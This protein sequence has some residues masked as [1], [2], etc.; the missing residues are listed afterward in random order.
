MRFR[1][2][3]SYSHADAAWAGWLLRRLET[4]RVPSRLVGTQGAHGLIERRLG[5]FFR[6]RDELP[7]AGDLGVTI[8]E[9]LADS[10]ALV[11]ICSPTAAQS[12]WVN[13]EVEAFQAG[14]HGDRVFCFVVGGVPGSVD[15]AQACFPPALVRP[16][17]NGEP[18]EP[19]AAD[20]RPEGDGRER[21]FLKLVA[22]LLGVGYDALAQREA[23]RR[24]RK[25]AIVAAAS[26]VGMTIAL[27][28]AAT[29]Y[30]ARNDA[31][32]RQAQAED[33]LGFMLGDLREK[34]TTVG[35]LDLMRSV[36]DKAIGY[37]ATLDPRDMT[38][39]ALEEQA[40]SLT[41]IGE[42]RLGEGNHDAAMAAFREAHAR[43][44]ALHQR[45]PD[46]GQRLFDLAQAEY[47]IGFVALEQGRY[48]DVEIWFRKY[49]DSAIKLAAMDRGNFEWQQEV[50]YG[51]HNL[52]ALDER[53]GRYV[54]AEKGMREV[55]RMQRE[56]SAT[57]PDDTAMRGEMAETMSWLGQVSAK[58][59][60]LEQAENFFKEEVS[61]FRRNI[62]DEPLN[63]EWKQ[64][65]ADSL[66]ILAKAQ[67]Q[68][69]RI[70]EAGG[71]VDEALALLNVLVES[72]AS[73]ANWRYSR[74]VA[75]WWKARLGSGVDSSLAEKMADDAVATLVPL[76]KIEP[77][78]WRVRS[79]L[80]RSKH[81]QAKLALVRNDIATAKA[82]LSDAARLIKPEWQSTQNESL[83][84]IYAE[85]L[86]LSGEIL[87]TS[88]QL[89]PA[90]E[91][92]LKAEKVLISD[93]G[94]V[95]PFERLDLLVRTLRHLGHME[96]S[97]HHEQR[98]SAAGYVPMTPWPISV[99]PE[100]RSGV[101][102]R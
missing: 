59:G 21:A 72:D 73:N 18:H 27:G 79:W 43:S 5:K 77:E 92:W 28:L 82:R 39:R 60:N 67:L 51:Y 45:A 34:L 30:V 85:D 37:F 42:V 46:N 71:S 26:L 52:A 1:A 61:A 55:L 20:A 95:L 63:S 41:G 99:S 44:T 38:D 19:L 69:G 70:A 16:D 17:A 12:R 4:Y 53:R 87:H 98:L 74:A 2:F 47:W 36:D 102:V 29:A 50:M 11:V 33:I 96:R 88:G 56:W 64:Q 78:N 84:L 91:S 81:L 93:V 80:V 32:R 68:R 7:S 48:D 100:S 54:E 57:R 35:R 40:R 75:Y 25:L 62:R 31:Q 6:D 3:L 8:R 24:T 13:A 49:R 23:Q 9:A 66:L 58:Q 86:M 65:F 94:N 22:G 14:G 15:P 89:E 97:A 83:R 101:A 10:A 90:R 76:L